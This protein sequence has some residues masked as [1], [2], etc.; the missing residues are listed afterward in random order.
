M[1]GK[2]PAFELHQTCAGHSNLE[3]CI[4]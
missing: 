2:L 3:G 1:N 4:H